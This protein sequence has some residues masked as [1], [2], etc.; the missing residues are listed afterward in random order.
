MLFQNLIILSYKIL[1]LNNIRVFQVIT[2]TKLIKHLETYFGS[3]ILVSHYAT[4]LVHEV[5]LNACNFYLEYT[6]LGSLTDF[7]FWKNFECWECRLTGV[8]EGL[9][10]HLPHNL[11]ITFNNLMLIDI[12]QIPLMIISDRLF[13][14]FFVHILHLIQ[15]F[16]VR[17]IK[18]AFCQ[19]LNYRIRLLCWRVLRHEIKVCDGL[20][21]TVFEAVHRRFGV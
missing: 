1:I 17:E 20:G 18:T 14:I 3:Q 4:V 5:V 10:W 15:T 16:G 2:Y 19:I 8:I 13:N 21:L 6:A 12:F 9:R 7:G 11:E